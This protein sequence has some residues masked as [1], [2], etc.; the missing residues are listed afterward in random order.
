[1]PPSLKQM[2]VQAR[3]LSPDDRAKLVQSILESLH[4]PVAEIQAAWAIEIEKRVAAFDR[5]E[6]HSYPTEDVFAEARRLMR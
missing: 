2:E 1:M 3:A 4:A 5:G 6:M